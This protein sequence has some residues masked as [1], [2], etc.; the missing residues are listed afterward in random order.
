MD[1]LE[2]V[3]SIDLFSTLSDVERAIVGVAAHPRIFEEGSV[4][5]TEGEVGRT[6]YAVGVG[7]LSVRKGKPPQEVAVLQP[8][9]YF[10]E[11]SLLTGEPRTATV[12][13][14][15]RSELLEF[16]RPAF[17]KLFAQNVDVARAVSEVV[18]MRQIAL[19]KFTEDAKRKVVHIE[20]SGAIFGR[21]KQLF[22]LT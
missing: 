20:Q 7:A 15:T 9:E 8:G 14:V 4:V 19:Q 10:G 6:F 17:M 3:R 16:D 21:I 2:L 22:G 13:A 5:C 11:M 1:K 18:A 12:V